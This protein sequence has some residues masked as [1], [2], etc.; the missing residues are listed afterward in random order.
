[1]TTQYETYILHAGKLR[2][3]KHTEYII[4]IASPRKRWLRE[5][6]TIFVYT[7]IVCLV[8]IS[9]IFYDIKLHLH[10][11]FTANCF[12]CRILPHVY[13]ATDRLFLMYH[14]YVTLASKTEHCGGSVLMQ[15]GAVTGRN[16][17]AFTAAF[18]LGYRKGFRKLVTFAENHHI[19]QSTE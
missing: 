1:M 8:L 14:S 10:T 5:R 18:A 4:H 17:F 16:T 2:P 9:D 7:Y 13:L 15:R 12:T 19:E 11:G 3:H 6:D